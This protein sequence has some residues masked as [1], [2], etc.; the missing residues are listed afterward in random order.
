MAAYCRAQ[1]HTHRS[2]ATIETHTVISPKH[3]CPLI[4]NLLKLQVKLMSELK[5]C[6]NL[7]LAIK[8]LSC[9]YIGFFYKIA[10]EIN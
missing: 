1:I 8:A 6:K 3:S 5:L 9:D 4:M 10:G 7:C 2:A